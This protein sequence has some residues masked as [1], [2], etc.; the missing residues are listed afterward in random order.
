MEK[1][2][3]YQL[4]KSKR[5]RAEGTAFRVGEAVLLGVTLV[6][7]LSLAVLLFAVNADVLFRDACITVFAFVFLA[8]VLLLCAF[9]FF[10]Y[11]PVFRRR[12][13]ARNVL[14]DCTLTD[15][16][17]LE[18]KT[19]KVR[20]TNSHRMYSYDVVAVCYS[21]YG[22]DGV[23]RY[24][25]YGGKYVR[26]PFSVGQKLMIAFCGT[27]SV[28]LSEYTLLNETEAKDDAAQEK[29]CR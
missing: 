1:P 10:R 14:K 27:E 16:T 20:R 2:Q 11:R 25:R 24:G 29:P 21:F 4:D 5:Y 3:F 13:H 15:G 9:G 12:R 18:V 17:V 7:F 26:N 19:D 8:I 6:V 22:T 23:L 28:I